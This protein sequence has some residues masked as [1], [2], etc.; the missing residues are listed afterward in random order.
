MD[1]AQASVCFLVEACKALSEGDNDRFRA[2]MM[3]FAV[4]NGRDFRPTRDE[5]LAGC[6]WYAKEL[7]YAVASGFA[8]DGIL[9]ALIEA[10]ADETVFVLLPERTDSDPDFGLENE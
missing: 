3:G 8:S 1:K 2:Q 9:S 10:F 6:R 7:A 4:V 5:F